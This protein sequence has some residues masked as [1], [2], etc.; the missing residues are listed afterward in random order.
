VSAG[1][2][3]SRKS[4][5]P[6]HVE[7]NIRTRR[8]FRRGQRILVAVSGGLDSTVLLHLLHELAPGYGWQLT[9]AHLNHRLRGRSSDADERLVRRTAEALE[10]PVRVERADVRKFAQAHNLSLEMAARK[11]RHDFLARTARQLRIPSVALAHHADDQL[12]L[13]FLRLFRGSGGEGL[14]GMKWRNPSPS[15]SEIELVRPLLGQPKSALRE[16]AAG[17][18]IQFREDISNAC[19][20]IQRNRIR[21]E[22]LPLLRSKYQRALDKTVLR[23]M[24]IVRGEAEFVTRA[25]LDWLAHLRMGEG[26]GGKGSRWKR[27][28]PG[29][30]DTGSEVD[31]PRRPPLPTIFDELP[32]AVQR[33]CVQLQ[34]L[35]QGIVTDYDLV[36]QLRAAADRPVTANRAQA[37]GEGE[38]GD[39]GPRATLHQCFAVRDSRGI[40]RLQV[41]ENQ[42]FNIGLVE[43]RLG[44]GAGDVEFAGAKIH[45]WIYLKKPLGQSPPS[46]GYEFFDAERVGTGI[47]LRHWRPGDRFQPIGMA[48]PIK[49]QDFFTNQKV[50]RGR[51]RELIVAATATG[52]LFWVEGMRISER[53]KLTKQTIRCLQWHC[54]RP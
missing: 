24:D 47:L 22:L 8:L 6:S 44:G 31:P 3:E 5:L 36:E 18:R 48:H 15:E 39:N 9:V 23:T 1:T 51:R 25:A 11:V 42:E 10:L 52:E 21:H 19:L 40:V 49:L 45:W 4:E 50:P 20:D 27:E 38:S 12:E 16:Y 14:A 37:R 30:D 28:S 54:E 7:Q 2:P 13:F 46:I 29:R 26:K 17:R 33:R 53:F 32:V 41:S 43:V 34:L 35:S